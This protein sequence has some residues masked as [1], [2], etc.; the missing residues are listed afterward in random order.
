MAAKTVFLPNDDACK[1][2]I[3]AGVSMSS[4]GVMLKEKGGSMIT[5]IIE[6]CEEKR[7]LIRKH[8]VDVMVASEGGKN[9]QPD[10]ESIFHD[11]L[12]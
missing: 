7:V 10:W 11:D 5:N 1:D 8:M 12:Q 6:P 2:D 4:K 9:Y 3:I